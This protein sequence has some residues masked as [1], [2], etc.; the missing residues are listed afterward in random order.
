MFG[1][2][3]ILFALILMVIAA[4]GWYWTRRGESVRRGRFFRASRLLALS[5]VVLALVLAI[6]GPQFGALA[7][8][9]TAWA[10]ILLLIGASV[11]EGVHIMCL[12]RNK[13]A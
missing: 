7:A 6:F 5:A 4:F 12:R 8:R 2:P 1:S 3:E 9:L 11:V 13:Q 10:I